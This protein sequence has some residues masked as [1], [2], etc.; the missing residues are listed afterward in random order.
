MY[1]HTLFS[2]VTRQISDRKPQKSHQ[3]GF[4]VYAY[5]LRPSQ[6]VLGECGEATVMQTLWG[7]N[8]TRAQ[9]QQSISKLRQ[10]DELPERPRENPI[11]LEIDRSR[12]LS[13]ARERE[14][15]C[16]LAFLSATSDDSLKVMAVCVEEHSN[17]K[18]I[19]IRI[20]SNAGDLSEV[21]RGFARIAR[22]LEHAARRGKVLRLLLI[23]I[24]LICH[25]STVEIRRYQSDLS[26]GRSFGS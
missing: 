4:S 10:L 6:I 11:H 26:R 18:G 16:N 17:G 15:A 22:E 21:T 1:S 19:T 13:V 20:V 3:N 23:P 5:P 14:I 12:Q 25:L 9:L 2:G 8:V 7:S 24:V